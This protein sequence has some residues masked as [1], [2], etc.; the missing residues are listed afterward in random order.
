MASL[1]YGQPGSNL[2]KIGLAISR[3]YPDYVYAAIELDRTNGGVFL[4][5]NRG[6]SWT[7]MSDTLFG[8]TGPH[9]YQELYASP[10]AEGQL[11]LRKKDIRVQLRHGTPQQR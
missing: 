2:G 8:A 1:E 6:A 3:H 11:H 5:R 9:Y 4:S 7:T 10:H